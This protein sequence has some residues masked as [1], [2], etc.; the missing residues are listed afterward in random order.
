MRPLGAGILGRESTLAPREREIVIDRT[1][2]RCECEYEWGVHVAAFGEACG[3]S[4]AQLQDTASALVTEE[5]WSERERVLIKLVDE[6]HET[7]TL[8]EATWAQLVGSWS[9]AQILEVLIIVGWYHLISFVA[10]A[11]HIEEEP[12][13]ARFPSDR[14]R[15]KSE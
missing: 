12:W 13:S 11:A 5:L 2:A 9:I 3:L 6:L 7:A 10:N 1:C 4:P 15:G 8:S 14:Q